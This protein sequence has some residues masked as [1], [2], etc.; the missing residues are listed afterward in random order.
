MG[1]NRKFDFRWV[2]KFCWALS[3]VISGGNWLFRWNCVFFQVGLCTPLRTMYSY[4]IVL[5]KK[6]I[7]KNTSNTLSMFLYV[8][9]IPNIWTLH[10]YFCKCI[11]NNPTSHSAPQP[12]V[13]INIWHLKAVKYIIHLKKRQT[14]LSVPPENIRKSRGFLMFFRGYRKRSMVWNGIT[15]KYR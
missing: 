3:N 5:V 14:T 11:Q 15:N 13:S 10:C 12:L 7:V 6:S 4:K 2:W 8:Y 9:H 1:M